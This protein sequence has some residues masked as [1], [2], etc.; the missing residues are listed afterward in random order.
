MKQSAAQT[1]EQITLDGLIQWRRIYEG[2]T[3]EVDLKEE[4]TFVG[5]EPGEPG[6]S[7]AAL[8]R[9]QVLAGEL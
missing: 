9:R 7:V 2:V 3:I 6:C 5:R 8:S 1:Q 4:E